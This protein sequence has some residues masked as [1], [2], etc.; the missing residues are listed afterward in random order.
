LLVLVRHVTSTPATQ[1]DQPLVGYMRLD[2]T[3]SPLEAMGTGGTRRWIGISFS[4][5]LL[6]A[7]LHLMFSSNSNDRA[8]SDL[9]AF[10]CSRVV[11]FYMG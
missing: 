2:I 4:R 9:C 8:L 3:V 5:S 10:A 7:R 6:E 1:S 11:G